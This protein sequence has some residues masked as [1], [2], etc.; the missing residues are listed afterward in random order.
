ME[1]C[2]LIPRLGEQAHHLSILRSVAHSDNTHTVAM[3][4]MLT[5]YRHAE[6][7][8][9]PQNKPNDFPTFGAVMQYLHPPVGSLPPGISLNSPA[10]QVSANNHI[11]PGF[12]AGFLGSRYDPLFISDDPSK[13]EFKPFRLAEGLTT[14]RLDRRRTLLDGFDRQWHAVEPYVAARQLTEHQQR[15]FNLTTSSAARTAFDLSLEPARVRERYGMH[16][17]GQGLLLARRLAQAGVP[18]ITV[19][20]M[21]DDAFWDT[22]SDNFKRMRDLLP[23]FDLAFSA[24]LEDLSSRGML[25]ETLVVC[26]GEF[27]RTP[28]INKSAG[29]D[30]WADCN[31]VVF[32]GGGVKG[33][34]IHGASDK[35]AAYPVTPPIYPE[36]LAATIYH[37]LG[38]DPRTE[39]RDPLNR[40]LPLT[41]GRPLLELFS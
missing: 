25:D 32:A 29:R 36:D 6:P 4:Y 22:H 16:P 21:R 28:Q 3:H 18:L 34:Q 12:F 9:N 39:L 8:T 19:N 15:A 23:P 14:S 10:N 33:G 11:F 38:V 17:F 30:H 20:W 7:Q 27:G 40:P 24:L 26:L 2:E 5:G 41:T 1:L 31:S 37:A 13:P 35:I